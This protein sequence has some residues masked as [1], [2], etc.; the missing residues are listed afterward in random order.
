[1]NKVWLMLALVLST[2]AYAQD[3]KPVGATQNVAPA[4]SDSLLDSSTKVTVTSSSTNTQ[5]SIAN[6]SRSALDAELSVQLEQLQHEVA[7]LRGV[8]E[9]QEHQIQQLKEENQNRYLDLDRRLAELNK[10][11]VASTPVV[12]SKSQAASTPE[13][14]YQQAMN[15]VRDK[16]YPQATELFER[17]INEFPTHELMSNALYWQGEVWLVREEPNKALKYFY[18]AVKEYP[19][20]TKA[21]DSAYKIGVVLHRQGKNSEAKT[22]LERVVKDY[23]GKADATVNLAKSY[24]SRLQ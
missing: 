13:T 2:G 24:L 9:Q 5:K 8:I 7:S 6:K 10:S 12:S 14:L 3:W 22:W 20:S 21:A 4:G 15:D 16:H 23:S 17:F 19:N 11:P 18:R 1:M